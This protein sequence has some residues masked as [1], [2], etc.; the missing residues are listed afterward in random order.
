[1]GNYIVLTLIFCLILSELGDEDLVREM[2]LIDEA[3]EEIKLKAE[4]TLKALR[5]SDNFQTSNS[6]NEPEELETKRPAFVMFR[7][8]ECEYSL[9]LF[10]K[11]NRFRQICYRI[12]VHPYFE[13]VVIFAIF[14]SCVKLIIDSYIYE[15]SHPYALNITQKFDYLYTYFFVSEIIIKVVSCGFGGEKGSYW[16]DHW[17]KVNFFVTSAGVLALELTTVKQLAFAK[18]IKHF[19]QNLMN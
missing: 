1:M 10:S 11:D 3:A 8:I 6:S 17:N 18:V 16:S 14:T 7:N 19:T 15:A 4:K 5:Q 9:Y 12:M 2:G 13:F